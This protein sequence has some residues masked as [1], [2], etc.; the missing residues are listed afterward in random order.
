MAAQRC[1]YLD[2]PDEQEGVSAH[3]LIELL[4]IIVML[5]NVAA[6]RQLAKVLH[7]GFLNPITAGPVYILAFHFFISTSNTSLQ[8]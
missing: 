7:F 2:E 6:H 1:L 4:D 3:S 8:R 5:Y